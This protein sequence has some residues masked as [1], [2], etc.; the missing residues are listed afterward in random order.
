LASSE[1]LLNSDS[2]IG[3]LKEGKRSGKGSMNY[4]NGDTY[5]GDWVNDQKEGTG[6]F[7][8]LELAYL[9]IKSAKTLIHF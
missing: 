4:V 8:V 9:H 1:G 3:D 5:N 7:L 2:Y 6:M